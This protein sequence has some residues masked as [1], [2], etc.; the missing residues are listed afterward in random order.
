[1]HDPFSSVRAVLGLL[2]D[3]SAHRACLLALASPTSSL[4]ERCRLRRGRCKILLNMGQ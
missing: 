3:R 4:L 2:G 1:M